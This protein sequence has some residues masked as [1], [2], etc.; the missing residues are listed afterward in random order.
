MTAKLDQICR[1]IAAALLD[2][3]GVQDASATDMQQARDDGAIRDIQANS[4]AGCTAT[5]GSGNRALVHQGDCL[6]VAVSITVALVIDQ[7]RVSDTANEIIERVMETVARRNDW[8]G[9][10]GRVGDAMACPIAETEGGQIVPLLIW[11]YTYRL[12]GDADSGVALANPEEYI[13]VS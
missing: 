7:T 11:A 3:E 2:V 5:V 9:L 6:D 8:A 1:A 12:Q 10:P 4:L 13:N